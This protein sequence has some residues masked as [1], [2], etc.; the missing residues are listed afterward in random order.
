MSLKKIKPGSFPGLC[1]S[2]KCTALETLDNA[3]FF[4]FFF[5][6]K[7]CQNFLGFMSYAQ[8][9]YSTQIC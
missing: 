3:M 9:L 5:F 4:F 8:K 2:T 7:A 6:L 1:F